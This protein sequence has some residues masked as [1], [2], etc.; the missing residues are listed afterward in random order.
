MELQQIGLFDLGEVVEACE[1]SGSEARR[2]GCATPGGKLFRMATVCLSVAAR[3][4]LLVVSGQG[5]LRV[6]RLGMVIECARLPRH[7]QYGI[8]PPVTPKT[9]PVM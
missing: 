7:N 3:L 1:S 6:W 9:S 5:G 8:R 4:R 2:A